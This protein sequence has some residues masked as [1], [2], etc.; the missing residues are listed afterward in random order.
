MDRPTYL[1]CYSTI[2]DETRDVASQHELIAENITTSLLE[3]INTVVKI[4]KE[5][6]KQCI[7]DRD[8]YLTEYHNCEKEL[9]KARE[10][11]EHASKSLERAVN[12][13]YHL[14]QTDES[15]KASVKDA[16]EK[17]IRKRN[18]LNQF[19][20]EYAAQLGKTNTIKSLYYQ[21]QLPKVFDVI[22]RN[23]FLNEFYFYIQMIF[24]I[25]KMMQGLEVKRIEAFRSIMN[26]SILF[27]QEV[28]PRIEKCHNQMFTAVKEIDPN[29]DIEKVTYSLKTG[30]K[31]PEDYKYQEIHI[32]NPSVTKINGSSEFLELK[33]KFKFCYFL[34]VVLSLIDYSMYHFMVKAKLGPF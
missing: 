30:L 28:I 18:T 9:L 23:E 10:N 13:H 32:P 29:K 33:F 22:K 11:Y 16:E 14:D 2:L 4:L 24:I 1:N 20:A 12:E 6:R 19:N 3:K 21:A 27:E 26:D 25:D 15:T 31:I 5:E 34:C 7:N 17:V 8:K